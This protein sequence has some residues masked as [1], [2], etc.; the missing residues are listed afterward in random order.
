VGVD[1][2]GDHHQIGMAALHHV[3]QRGELPAAR[4]HVKAGLPE[5]PAERF[6]HEELL[7]RDEDAPAAVPR[8]ARVD[9]LHRQLLHRLISPRPRD[10][11]SHKQN[12]SNNDSGSVDARS[13]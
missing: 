4:G 3:E 5:Q 7:E 9:L 10:G 11:P 12:R 13:R 8:L 2:R 6:C 1:P